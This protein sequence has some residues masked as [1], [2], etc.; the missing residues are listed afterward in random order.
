MKSTHLYKTVSQLVI[1][2]QTR[3][4]LKSLPEYLLD[5]LGLSHEQIKIEIKKSTL[6]SFCQELLRTVFNVQNG[7][8]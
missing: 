4:Q 2:Q 8:R 6:R 5:D 1:K 7:R 3:R